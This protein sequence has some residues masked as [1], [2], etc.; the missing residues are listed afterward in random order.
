MLP[1]IE[2]TAVQVKLTMFQVKLIATAVEIVADS[3]MLDLVTILWTRI[4]GN[5]IDV[6]KAKTKNAEISFVAS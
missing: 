3:T 5:M 1:V 6:R 4:I 2:L